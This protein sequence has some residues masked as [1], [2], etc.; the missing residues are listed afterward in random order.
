VVRSPT[1]RG[2]RLATD[3]R[4]DGEAVEFAQSLGLNPDGIAAQFRDYWH[5]KPGKEAVKLDWPATWRGWCRR[6]AERR[7][8]HAAAKPGKLDWLIADMR[9]EGPIQ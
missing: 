8:T 3:W 1:P 9:G 7:P 6:E 2:S 5:A 4:P